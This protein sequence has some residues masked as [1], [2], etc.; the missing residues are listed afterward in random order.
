[1]RN[2]FYLLLNLSFVSCIALQEQKSSFSELQNNRIFQ[3]QNHEPMRLW[4]ITSKSDSVL[5]RQESTDIQLPE[6]QLIAEKLARGLLTTV[7]DTANPGVGIA[8]P[9]VGV[10]KNMILVQRFDKINN[11]YEIYLNPTIGQFSKLKQPCLEG[12][13]SIPNRMDTTRTRAY[14]I[15]LTYQTM[16]GERKTEL[17]ED[18]TAVIF[19]HEIDHLRGILYIDHLDQELEDA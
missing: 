7:T 11:P 4:E 3:Y 17:V 15:L 8:A 16:E 2:L 10:L 1:M 14:A 6:D 5:L 12:C 13:L 18:F 9:Q 19:Q